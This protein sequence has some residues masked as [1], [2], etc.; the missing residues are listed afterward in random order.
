MSGIKDL[1]NNDL[2]FREITKNF[3][4][5]D[6][7]CKTIFILAPMYWYLLTKNQILDFIKKYQKTEKYC[8]ITM[9]NIFLKMLDQY[10][11]KENPFPMT[12]RILKFKQCRKSTDKYG[13]E[14]CDSEKYCVGKCPPKNPC[15]Y[16]G[17]SYEFPLLNYYYKQEEEAKKRKT[18]SDYDLIR[19][20]LSIGLVTKDE[21]ILDKSL[22]Y[23][24]K[25]IPKPFLFNIFKTLG[26]DIRSRKTWISSGPINYLKSNYKL[27]SYKEKFDK[28]KI[29]EQTY[30][31]DNVSD[32]LKTYWVGDPFLTL[33][34]T[35]DNENTIFNKDDF[36]FCGKYQ[37]ILTH[38]NKGKKVFT[39]SDN[40]IIYFKEKIT[41][42]D[43]V[44]YNEYFENTER[45]FLASSKYKSNKI[46]TSWTNYLM[47]LLWEKPN[48]YV[49]SNIPSK[50]HKYCRSY[51]DIKY[52]NIQSKC[53]ERLYS[54]DGFIRYP[55]SMEQ[56]F[57]Y[58]KCRNFCIEFS[59]TES[60]SNQI[61]KL[62]E[63]NIPC[64]FHYNIT[65]RNGNDSNEIF[66]IDEIKI[67]LKAKEQKKKQNV[68]I[69][70]L[71]YRDV[72]LN[73]QF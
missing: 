27:P 18:L 55:L 68:I 41:I 42:F 63:T 73:R 48:V 56:S 8:L 6:D 28:L 4:D 53:Y 19:L 25:V 21:K 23:Y 45:I 29:K 12:T 57:W 36:T 10:Q 17:K 54:A 67:K 52:H 13:D 65:N 14:Q 51:L 40:A 20:A 1:L 61:I 72:L 15:Y 16:K 3:D 50:L 44:T 30:I 66:N 70:K 49:M 11:P 9:G 35:L 69:N 7:L 62:D 33:L 64:K 37:N 43:N 34:L 32:I 60:K 59:N 46:C 38:K 26:Q 2:I 47:E 24:W 5:D 31:L 22:K 71:S 39:N 58:N